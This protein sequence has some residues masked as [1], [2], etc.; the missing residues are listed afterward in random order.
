[1][2]CWAIAGPQRTS[3]HVVFSTRQR[4]PSRGDRRGAAMDGRRAL[5]VG[6]KRNG[7]CRSLVDAWRRRRDRVAD[8]LCGSSEKGVPEASPGPSPGAR[9]RGV[10]AR[11][12][13]VRAAPRAHIRASLASAK[14]AGRSRARRRSSNGRASNDPRADWR[15]GARLS[16]S[17]SI[18]QQTFR[19]TG[20]ICAGECA[21]GAWSDTSDARRAGA[22]ANAGLVAHARMAHPAQRADGRA[23]DVQLARTSERQ[24]PVPLEAPSLGRCWQS[25][26]T[27]RTS[28][29]ELRRLRDASDVLPVDRRMPGDAARRPQNICERERILHDRRR[30]VSEKHQRADNRWALSVLFLFVAVVASFVYYIATPAPNWRIRSSTRAQRAQSAILAREVSVVISAAAISCTLLGRTTPA[31]CAR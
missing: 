15:L 10:P 11:A 6:W 2:I 25:E 18:R 27:W 26:S 22:A 8:A 19:D 14:P 3:K 16:G 28:G 4:S 30:R 1:M 7:A 29:T 23:R 12:R 17:R 20:R 24:P 9:P 13:G 31:S 5:V 21:L